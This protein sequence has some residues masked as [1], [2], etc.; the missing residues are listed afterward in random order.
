MDDSIGTQIVAYTTVASTAALLFDFSITFDSE[1]RWTWGRKWEITRIAFVACRYLPF[2]S[3]A[4]LT[5]YAVG[6]TRGGIVSSA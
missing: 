6:S 2:A 1:I 4:I 5:Y 3:L